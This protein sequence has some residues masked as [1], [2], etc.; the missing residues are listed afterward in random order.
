[1]VEQRS[2]SVS[3]LPPPIPPQVSCSSL[4]S[5]TVFDEQALAS[6]NKTVQQSDSN[7][8]IA[9]STTG[10][11]N[12]FNN[13][14]TVHKSRSTSPGGVNT[15]T[16]LLS[17]GGGGDTHGGAQV[18]TLTVGSRDSCE[19][20]SSISSLNQS[21]SEVESGD[22]LGD[23]GGSSGSSNESPNRPTTSTAA[24]TAR[25][26]SP[27]L[28]MNRLTLVD[29]PKHCVMRH[30]APYVPTIPVE[31]VSQKPSHLASPPSA[32]RL[33]STS[34]HQAQSPSPQAPSSPHHPPRTL[35]SSPSNTPTTPPMS[36]PPVASEG[37]G[38]GG[39]AS[40]KWTELPSGRCVEVE[41]TWTSSPINFTVRAIHCMYIIIIEGFEAMSGVIH[42]KNYGLLH[43]GSK[44]FSNATVVFMVSNA[45]LQLLLLSCK[46]ELELM[47]CR[48]QQ[49]I[50]AMSLTNPHKL[51]TGFVCAVKYSLDSLWY[52]AIV[53]QPFQVSSMQVCISTVDLS[54][55]KV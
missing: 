47:S 19:E 54:R 23:E 42:L 8:G 18:H 6:V 48:L 9:S 53:R 22:A 41:V 15:G 26:S 50:P 21:A 28:N 51:S 32:P 2:K 31:A 29:S 13:G 16:L 24:Q 10:G 52:R 11:A 33:A 4:A 45:F 55:L 34:S 36:P 40:Y 43:S 38:A 39:G 17:G 5:D 14:L 7:L 3:S 35:V 1:M 20:S 44:P 27:L 12:L 37:G 25:Q 49:L 46:A 30:D